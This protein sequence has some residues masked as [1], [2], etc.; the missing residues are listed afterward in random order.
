M[1]L[2]QK[3]I[4]RSTLRQGFSLVL[5]RLFIAHRRKNAKSY[6]KQKKSVQPFELHGFL[7]IYRLS[8]LYFTSSNLT[9]TENQRV[10]NFM[11]QVRDTISIL[12]N[13]N[14]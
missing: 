11:V 10:I 3:L 6:N 13:R 4:D 8:I 5:G 1:F 12:N 2:Y 9:H 14:Q 7:F